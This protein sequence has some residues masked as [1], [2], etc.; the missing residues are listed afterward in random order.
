MGTTSGEG[1]ID[2]GDLPTL[3]LNRTYQLW[4]IVGDRVISV[5]LIARPA[6]WP[7]TQDAVHRPGE[8]RPG[9]VDSSKVGP[10]P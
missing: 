2:A 10:V 9:D 8:V 6:S 4:A 5:G 7:S 3:A 1:F